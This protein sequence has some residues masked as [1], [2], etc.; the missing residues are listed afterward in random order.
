MTI[1]KNKV[2]AM[3]NREQ[4]WE[5]MNFCRDDK[6]QAHFPTYPLGPGEMDPSPKKKGH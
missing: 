3:Q 2:V 6:G 1:S 5:R 4:E